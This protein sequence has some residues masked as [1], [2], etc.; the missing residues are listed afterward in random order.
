MNA[1]QVK[2]KR[3]PIMLDKKRNLVMDMNALCAI[4]QEYGSIDEA[5]MGMQRKS[6]GAI[7][8]ILWAGILHEFPEGKEPT[9]KEMARYVG[10]HNLKDILE[11]V[12]EAFDEALP[13]N[14]VAAQP[15]QEAQMT[16]DGIGPSS[17]ISE[18]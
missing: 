16:M 11:A 6:V 15:T 5:F 14:A 8:T 1:D 13:K 9:Q 2:V 18:Q 17:Y 10:L 3:V 7:R 4:E 12:T